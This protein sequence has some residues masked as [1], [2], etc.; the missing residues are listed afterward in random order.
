MVTLEAKY[1]LFSLANDLPRNTNFLHLVLHNHLK[2]IRILCAINA[3]LPCPKYLLQV[4]L[5]FKGLDKEVGEIR[6]LL[7]Y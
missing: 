7:I 2:Y 3:S 6:E 4:S 5:G 1:H